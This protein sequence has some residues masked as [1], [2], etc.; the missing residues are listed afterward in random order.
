MPIQGLEREAVLITQV[1]TLDDYADV[2]LAV[3]VFTNNAIKSFQPMYVT[4]TALLS[5]DRDSHPPRRKDVGQLRIES[6]DGPQ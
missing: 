4:P 1:G 6:V 5:W 2:T 3:E